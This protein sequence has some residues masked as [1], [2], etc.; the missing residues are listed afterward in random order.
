MFPS[1]DNNFIAKI[2][3]TKNAG[4]ADPLN[5]FIPNRTTNRKPYKKESLTVDEKME[6]SS[7]GDTG[8]YLT[9]LEGIENISRLATALSNNE[10]LILENK[11]VHDGIFKSIRWTKT[12]ENHIKTGLYIKTLELA[13]PQEF[14]FKLFRNW[15]ILNF[16][17]K[18]G[19]SKMVAKD[20]AKLYA[21]SAA[22]GLLTIE[23]YTNLSFVK[24]GR[25]LQRI[26]L[27][28]TKLNINVQPTAALLYLSQRIEA[29]DNQY[30]SSDQITL[31]QNS[32]KEINSLFNTLGKIPAMLFRLGK[33]APPSV[34]SQKRTPEIIVEN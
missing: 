2:T 20:T 13:A 7:F 32:I 5:S 26:W 14:A 12:E 22:Y 17:N 27:T 24:T 6:L 30:F 25:V 21:S 8:V 9:F 19:V 4:Q 34:R 16:L 11:A 15:S 23:N 1:S 28:A 29:G 31:I 18:F 33:G 10:R 3:F